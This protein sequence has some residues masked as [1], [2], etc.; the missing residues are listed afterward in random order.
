LLLEEEGIY[1]E[2]AGAAA[3]AGW[4]T[5][6]HSGIVRD[7]ES[8]VCLVTGHGFKDLASIEEA[9]RQHPSVTVESEDLRIV[10]NEAISNAQ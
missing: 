2:P 1:S 4:I 7:G 3:L 10:L 9:A 6:R 5:A 8:S